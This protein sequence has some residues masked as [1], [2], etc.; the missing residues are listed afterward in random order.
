[1]SVYVWSMCVCLREWSQ[2]HCVCP[3]GWHCTLGQ[4]IQ[5]KQTNIHS[6]ILF[7]LSA[8][9]HRNAFW[10]ITEWANTRHRHTHWRSHTHCV[11]FAFDSRDEY[12][13]V[14]YTWL[15]ELCSQNCCCC[16]VFSSPLRY[17]YI[18]C[19]RFTSV[20]H[21]ES[22]ILYVVSVS[23]CVALTNKNQILCIKYYGRTFRITY[24]FCVW[25]FFPFSLVFFYFI[26]F[27]IWEFVWVVC[28][29]CFSCCCWLQSVSLWSA[30]VRICQTVSSQLACGFVSYVF[31]C[32]C[33]KMLFSYRSLQFSLIQYKQFFS[34]VA[35]LNAKLRSS[36]RPFS[37]L[38]CGLS[39]GVVFFLGIFTLQYI[40]FSSCFFVLCIVVQIDD[41]LSAFRVT[42][43]THTTSSI[44]SEWIKNIEQE[45][46]SFFCLVE[47]IM[48][49]LY[50]IF[51]LR[52]LFFGGK[53]FNIKNKSWSVCLHVLWSEHICLFFVD[54]VGT[55]WSKHHTKEIQHYH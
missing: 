49:F 21:W 14:M 1:M 17:V 44:H 45:L 37:R 33:V 35:F 18:L 9:T 50:S 55:G 19:K 32:P 23:V 15:F 54:V 24:K 26:S 34:S 12:I 8:F 22:R 46:V 4:Y 20:P 6:S 16:R 40:L 48:Y 13:V 3:F 31:V 10:N 41:V 47:Y 2:Q 28:F 11:Y 43:G 5:S 30:I 42:G 27:P 53:W 25:V 38:N 52:A 29:F 39:F 7:T 51:S 36:L